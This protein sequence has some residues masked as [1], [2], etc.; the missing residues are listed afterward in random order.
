MHDTRRRMNGPRLNVR[1][2]KRDQDLI[3]MLRL[4]EERTGMDHAKLVKL[5]L[6]V[7]LPCLIDGC[8][9]EGMCAFG[10]DT[11]KR[12]CALRT[13][14]S[15]AKEDLNRVLDELTA[16][17]ERTPPGTVHGPVQFKPAEDA[18]RADRI[19]ER[20]LDAASILS[21]IAESIK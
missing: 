9:Q 12:V 2:G 5:A 10:G 16:E 7:V 15:T 6:R 4:T 18:A 20:V 11:S 1:L 21:R 14:A 17:L 3:D 19:R 8:D 13:A